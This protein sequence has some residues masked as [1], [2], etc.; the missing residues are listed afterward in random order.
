MCLSLIYVSKFYS[1]PT[2][3][4]DPFFDDA[5]HYTVRESEDQRKDCA[6]LLKVYIK[7]TDLYNFVPFKMSPQ[8]SR[9]MVHF[10]LS[11]LIPQENLNLSQKG[12]L[13][14]C[15]FPSLQS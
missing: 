14:H 10:P 9:Y 7:K 4:H 1:L 12:Q 13:N 2:F 6:I 11:S 5:T 15:S 8:M 3:K